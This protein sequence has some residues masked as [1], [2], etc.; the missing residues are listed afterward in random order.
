MRTFPKII[1]VV[2]WAVLI[3][4]SGAFALFRQILEQKSLNII[5]KEF[6]FGAASLSFANDTLSLMLSNVSD[7][8]HTIFIERYIHRCTLSS[9]LALQFVE[10][11]FITVKNLRFSSQYTPL[12][13]LSQPPQKMFNLPLGKI[14]ID[15]ATISF[16]NHPDFKLYNVT[17]SQNVTT[18]CKGFASFSG[19]SGHFHIK[20]GFREHHARLSWTI[21]ADSFLLKPLEFLKNATE[22]TPLTGKTLVKFTNNTIKTHSSFVLA[23]IHRLVHLSSETGQPF[24][25][26]I[27]HMSLRDINLL[28]N[29]LVHSMTHY[30]A[31][32]LQ[33]LALEDIVVTIPSV[34]G[35]PDWENAFVQSRL[36]SG[37]VSL[38]DLG[39]IHNITGNF[40]FSHQ[41]GWFIG[42]QRAETSAGFVLQGHLDPC[43]AQFSLSAPTKAAVEVF[44][45]LNILDKTLITHIAGTTTGTLMFPTI[46]TQDW[47]DRVSGSFITTDSSCSIN[48]SALPRPILAKNAALHVAF[49]NS[50]CTV[51][52]TFIWEKSPVKMHLFQI[53]D[54]KTHKTDL[55]IDLSMDYITSATMV[56]FLPFLS[57]LRKGRGPTS[58]HIL[59]HCRQNKPHSFQIKAHGYGFTPF[60][61]CVPSLQK[62]LVIDQW[63][64]DA[65]FK[66]S[67]WTLHNIALKGP[68]IDITLSGTARENRST[69]HIA[70]SRYETLNNIE[71]SWSKVPATEKSSV[72]LNIPS[73]HLNDVQLLCLQG[74]L[75][76]TV[77]THVNISKFFST[78]KHFVEDVRV[79]FNTTVSGASTL[80]AY[81]GKDKAISPVILDAAWDKQ[82]L[83]SCTVEG[84][85]FSHLIRLTG[86]TTNVISVGPFTLT[87]APESSLKTLVLEAKD[88]SIVLPSQK[89]SLFSS[90]LSSHSKSLNF[91]EGSLKGTM[92]NN[93]LTLEKASLDS[94][95]LS[96]FVHHGTI[97][98]VKGKLSL[99]GNI[100]PFKTV[101]RGAAILTPALAKVFQGNRA[102]QS[103][104]AWHFNIDEDFPPITP[105]V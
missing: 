24:V 38:R 100:S 52:G 28:T 64:V 85:S 5:G 104:L 12:D 18:Q 9:L 76:S 20:R 88:I 102:L 63:V 6:S 1:F 101:K 65:L 82:A 17:V 46:I 27:K 37:T 15:K 66:D 31:W 96:V 48:L 33:D 90:I 35:L 84:A 49:K 103:P 43:S 54:P 58:I 22:D 45:R 13:L 87:Y 14:I 25:A 36:N 30:D 83:K 29:N 62:P 71:G 68:S 61:Y 86:I 93:I 81:M 41:K 55:A 40:Q 10:G 97:D 105:L 32:S 23:G 53:R 39:P 3:V 98:F 77:T 80:S 44:T 34:K 21:P 7:K 95:D 92:D 74:T 16:K 99:S 73:M 56:T 59:R 91:K 51:D 60:I 75:G 50:L 4:S 8:T 57:P 69:F 11:S 19:I 72:S 70:R 94:D 26:H 67:V 79:N 78:K 2:A 89:Q 47:R 42:V